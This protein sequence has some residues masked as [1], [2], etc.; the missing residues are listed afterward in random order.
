MFGRRLNEGCSCCWPY[1]SF[2]FDGSVGNEPPIWCEAFSTPPCWD[3]D[4]SKIEGWD[5]P[6][7]G[8]VSCKATGMKFVECVAR[9]LQTCGGIERSMDCVARSD[10]PP[11]ASSRVFF[12]SRLPSS[13]MHTRR[14]IVSSRS[15]WCTVLP[16]EIQTHRR[17]NALSMP[18]GV[19]RSLTTQQA[20]KLLH[21]PAGRPTAD[22][23]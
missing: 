4:K 16:S 23:S 17:S 15:E 10:D 20:I 7:L 19:L 2:Q 22:G 9:L 11:W 1:E 12:Y 13:A 3:N 18:T 8:R 21:C 14:V 5:R 6:E